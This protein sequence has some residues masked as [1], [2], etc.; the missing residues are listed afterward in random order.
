VCFQSAFAHELGHALGFNSDVD[1]N[2]GVPFLLDMFRFQSSTQHPTSYESFRTLP[3]LVDHNLP[4]DDHELG[5][6]AFTYAMADGSPHQGSHFRD[7]TPIIGVMDPVIDVGVTYWPELFRRADLRVLDAL[8]YDWDDPGLDPLPSLPAIT[9]LDENPNSADQ[10]RWQVQFDRRVG[11]VTAGDFSLSAPAGAS[12]ASVTAR[13]GNA[14]RFNGGNWLDLMGFPPLTTLNGAGFTFSCWVRPDVQPATGAP[15]RVILSIGTATNGQGMILWLDDT[16]R[17]KLD[18]VGQP[19]TWIFDP[20]INDGQWHFIS[21]S[22][23]PQGSPTTRMMVDGFPAGGSNFSLTSTAGTCFVGATLPGAPVPYGFIGDIDEVRFFKSELNLGAFLWNE[24][25][26]EPSPAWTPNLIGLFSFDDYA[27]FGFGF[28]SLSDT[29]EETNWGGYGEGR[30]VGF[31][32]PLHVPGIVRSAE[33]Y[34]LVANTGPDSGALMPT[35]HDDDSNFDYRSHAPV[36]GPGNGGSNGEV[37]T[38]QHASGASFCEGTGC[39]C[40]NDPVAGTNVGCL[41]SIGLGGRLRASGSTSIAAGTLTLLGSQMPNSN[42]LYLA[43]NGQT[44]SVLG[45]GVF[46]AGGT[47]VRLG[48]K[49]NVNGASQFPEAG[50]LSIATR[51]SATPGSS[52]YCQVWYRNA[53]AFCTP[54]TFN[55]TN[56]W[57]LTWTP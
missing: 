49:L 21:V 53:A 56:A 18:V 16:N 57:R 54:A 2:S 47:I 50:Q 26:A 36:N 33:L 52:S 28:P 4:N 23:T 40:A 37:Y 11:P 20:L 41:S 39:P 43:G 42:A 14:L 24:S 12:I 27:D 31:T 17:V 6:V 34:T 15:W 32:Q 19:G 48:T 38:V 9:R 7:Q 10:V 3:R 13:T 5:L 25:P 1:V 51:V 8:G 30:T 44:S 22:H 35:F 46:C 29:P 45:D 55:D